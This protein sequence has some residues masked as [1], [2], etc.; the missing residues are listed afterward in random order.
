MMNNLPLVA[1][2]GWATV[3]TATLS[4]LLAGC[5]ST[6]RERQ[7]VVR[8]E[9]H[10]L[11]TLARKGGRTIARLGRQTARLDSANRARRKQPLSPARTREMTRQLLGSTGPVASL[12]PATIG[13]AYQQLLRTARAKQ[14]TWTPRDWDYA[15]AVYASLNT[16]L[17][18][19][20]LDLP[21]RD[22]LRIRAWQTEF[23][24]MQARF[25]T[26]QLK[27]Q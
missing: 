23:V 13:A 8:E 12:T 24:S 17:K 5:D 11:D 4:L 3:L 19:I 26:R 22:E 16:Q 1:R 7:E 2:A 27:S 18:Q 6:P 20:R 9:A 21:A 15:R 10:K 25:Q 14:A